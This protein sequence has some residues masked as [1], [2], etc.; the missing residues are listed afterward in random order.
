MKRYE[1]T[2]PDG[3]DGW[4]RTEVETPTPRAGQVLVKVKAVSLNYRDLLL[5]QNPN[6]TM[7]RV[8]LS[9][10]AGE[11]AA[12]GEDVTRVKVGDRV[13]GLF[14]QTWI[15]GGIRAEHHAS[16]M[17]GA[18]DGMLSEYVVLHENGVTPFPNGFGYEEAAT[19]PCAAVTLWNALFEQSRLCPGETVL[20]LGT[21]GVSIFALQ[22][23]KAA[24]AKVI[25]TSSSDE[26]LER[27]KAL[28]ADETINYKTT[29]DWDK[30]VWNLT[31]KLGVDHVVEVGGAGTLEK[32]LKS[33]RTGGTVSLIGVLTGVETQVNPAAILFKSIRV[34]GIYVG[35]RAM[36]ERMNTALAQNKIKPVIHAVFEFDE[37]PEALRQLG[38]AGHFG[39]IVIRV[40]H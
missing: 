1:L 39:K 30:A 8:P 16:A 12:I 35:S 9:D 22:F 3:A 26:K 28:G 23:A 21:G 11:V 13:A 40:G 32:S 7:P 24:G 29:P 36:F 37:A 4:R 18:V 5:S 10:G 31:G 19:L 20:V 2:T 25:L 38:K 34:N 15:D 27:G 17:G 14:F 6:Q 33:V